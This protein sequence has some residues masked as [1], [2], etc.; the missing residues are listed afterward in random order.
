[1]HSPADNEEI[2]RV[3][4]FDPEG[5]AVIRRM[6]DG[7][8]WLILNSLPPANAAD[9]EEEL[10]NQFA[11]HLQEALGVPV[12]QD[13]RERFVVPAPQEDTPERIA[14]FL[15]TCRQE[16][17]SA[18]AKE[19]AKSQR[20][21]T[22]SRLGQLFQPAGFRR[23]KGSSFSRS[24]PQ[25]RQV[26]SMAWIDR[27]PEYQFTL[28][29]GIRLDV[30]EELAIP[31]LGIPPSYTAETLTTLTQ[32]EHF[33]LE[34]QL[35]LGV[36]FPASNSAELDA[37]FQQLAPVIQRQIL[38]FLDR[39]QT[40]AAVAG[41][42]HSPTP[43]TAASSPG[44]GPGHLLKGLVGRLFARRAETASGPPSAEAAWAKWRQERSAFDSTLHPARAVRHLLMAY[45][46]GD[47]QLEER[48]HSY[49]AELAPYT[50][51]DCE[52]L[53][54]AIRFIQWNPDHP[55]R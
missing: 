26:V 3:P 28:T 35:G 27:K 2:L 48:I 7:S 4:G 51:P 21:V 25:G 52:L 46:T 43:S 5:E 53:E 8:L 41:A 42:L 34:P 40:L 10:F 44:A 6:P 17:S 18:T 50:A 12:I 9:G 49:R 24:I 33:G 20:A 29:L 37:A 23:S 32:L 36:W 14:Q 39:H 31:L 54:E 16:R 30:V 19:T 45:L 55:S 11:Q 22:L 47:P 13:D 38:P 1:M 15:T